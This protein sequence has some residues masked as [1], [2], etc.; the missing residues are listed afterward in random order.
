MATDT[1][2]QIVREDP[3]IEAYRLG[4]LKQ[5]KELADTP[6]TLPTQQ[7]AGLSTLQQE[8][9][10]R[11]QDQAATGIGAYAPYM[12][13]A[14]TALN[15]AQQALDPSSLQGFMNPYQQAVQ[16]EIVRSY[17]IQA[18]QAGLGAAGTPGGPSA[19][20]GGR[21]AIQ[22]A[23]IGR[24]MAQSLA[25]AQA[26]AFQNAQQQQL[27]QSDAF[28]R[29][30]LQQA[31][32][33]EQAQGLQQKEGSYMFDLGRQL[34]AQQQAELEAERQS[35]LGQL[36]EPY[37]RMGFLSDIYKGAPTT[38]QTITSA[39]SPNVSPAQSILGMGIAGLSAYGG[40]QKAG[41]F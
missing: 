37:Q 15:A 31:S 18:Q 25:Q 26:A 30:G 19:F 36:Y 16:D 29:V 33:G 9:Q 34:Q 12:G 40:A 28:G 5:S 17:G 11:A 27:A 10:K 14:Q 13:Q 22:Q 24:N 41:L 21:A 23:E 3:D 32:L 7:V 20:G 38:Q 1:Q 4:L 8:A 2:I 6:I 35:N 39:T